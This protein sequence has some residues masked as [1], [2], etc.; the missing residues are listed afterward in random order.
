ME[1][2][3]LKNIRTRCWRRLVTWTALSGKSEADAQKLVSTTAAE[4]AGLGKL[5]ANWRSLIESRL[6][7]DGGGLFG[8]GS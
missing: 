8:G 6:A 1:S 3:I 4:Q 2:W 7:A 5:L